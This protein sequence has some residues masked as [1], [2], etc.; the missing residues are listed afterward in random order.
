[1]PVF[2]EALARFKQQPALKYYDQADHLTVL[3]YEA[4]AQAV[5]QFAAEI[6]GQAGFN[7]ASPQR[8]LIFL[9]ASNRASS[10]IAY[11]ACLQHN[12][13]LMLLDEN[14]PQPQLDRLVQAYQ[15]NFIVSEQHLTHCHRNKIQL[16]E[17]LA[18]LL[19]T[20]GSTGSPKQVALSKTN[21][22]SNAQSICDYLPI[23][24]NHITLTT[25]PM[26][27]SYG[28]SVINSHLLQGACLFLNEASVV[29]RAFWQTLQTERVSSVAGV[30][31]VWEMLLRLGFTKKELPFLRYFTQAGGKLAPKRVQILQEYAQA[32]NKAFYVMYGQTEATARMAFLAPEKLATKPDSIGRAIPGGEL[33]LYNQQGMRITEARSEGE[34]RYI[35]DNVMLGYALCQSDLAQFQPQLSLATGDLAYFDEQGD[36]FI[37]GRIKRFIKIHGLRVSL[38]EVETLLAGNGIAALAVGE[39]N[40]LRVAA[41]QSSLAAAT[42]TPHECVTLL[43]SL[44]GVHHTT[45][46]CLAVD[47]LLITANGKP[48]YVAISALFASSS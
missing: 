43:A 9:L 27:Y 42:K 3:S 44:L 36:F 24:A 12:H 10:L 7:L 30:P 13:V 1:M 16:D 38:D 32:N 40:K 5:Q 41:T 8:Q 47:N 22:H 31:Y 20:S 2:F 46:R 28:L 39:D 29:D 25:L 14:T 19:S 17:S 35:G 18:L 37:T 34:L 6:A 45:I 48:D 21:L 33:Q 11:L 23:E 26:H 15:P 4:L